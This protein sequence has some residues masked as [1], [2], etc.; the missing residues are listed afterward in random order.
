MQHVL[1]PNLTQSNMVEFEGLLPEN[2]DEFRSPAFWD[3]F[4]AKRKQKA[5]EWYGSYRQLRPLLRQACALD[6]DKRVL[7]PGC[8][9]SDLS[10]DMCASDLVDSNDDPVIQTLLP[11]RYDD[12]V[13]K[14]T[15][16]DFSRPV[17]KE[18]IFK[19]LRQNLRPLMRWL[20]GD[21]THMKVGA[22]SLVL[23]SVLTV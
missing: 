4:F 7:V 21:M 6:S 23:Y 19:N 22:I 10:A 15:N 16:I 9:N 8:G 12:G 1:L 20:V 3:G 5:F 18:M 2:F 11:P 17:I 14:I 13:V